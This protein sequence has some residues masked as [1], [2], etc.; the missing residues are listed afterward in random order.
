MNKPSGRVAAEKRPLR[1]AQDF[2]AVD[3]EEQEPCARHLRNVGL[4]DIDRDRAFDVRGEVVVGDAADADRVVGFP[5][6][7]Q[8]RDAGRER[9]HFLRVR[10]A[11]RLKLLARESGDRNADVLRVFL[12]LLRSDHDLVR[13][14]RS[15]RVGAGRREHARRRRHQS[16]PAR[17]H[18]VFHKAPLASLFPPFHWPPPARAAPANFAMICSRM[19]AASLTSGAFLPFATSLAVKGSKFAGI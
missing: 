16:L 4:V 2:D 1:P 15:L 17:F 18:R 10:V 8:G 14:D 5:V 6:R 13:K 9:R 11:E 7:L 3:V 12:A 19:R